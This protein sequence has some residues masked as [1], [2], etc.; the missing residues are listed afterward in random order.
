GKKIMNTI[1]KRTALIIIL[2]ILSQQNIHAKKIVT[3]PGLTTEETPTLLT[4][5]WLDIQKKTTDTV[6]QVFVETTEFNWREPYKTPEQNMASGSAFFIDEEGHLLSNF[7]VVNQAASIKIQ[8]PS[9]GKQRLD[10]SIVG[11]CPER[12]ISLLKLSQ[13]SREKI[14]TKL[15]KIPF[16][17]FG[18]SDKILRTHQVLALGYPL[19]QEKL[20]STQ[21]I[22]SGRENIEMESYIQTTAP[23]NPG[24]SG[25]PA[26]DENGN[27]IGLST[28]NIPE[29][30]NVGYIIPINNVKNIINDLHSTKLLRRPFFGCNLNYGTQDM[31]GYLKNPEPGGLY[32]SHVYKNTLFAKTGIKEGDMLYAINNHNIDMYGETNVQWSEDKVSFI[33]L[34][35]RFKLAEKITVDLYR[36]GTKHTFSFNFENMS[37]LPIRT[38]YP[39]YEPV[40]FEI[41]GGMVIMQLSLNHIN[42]F[43]EI[44]KTIFKYTRLENQLV[45]RLLISHVLPNSQTQQARIVTAGDIVTHVNGQV[46]TTLDELRNAVKR[47]IKFLSVKTE[48]KEFVV[49][50]IEKIV[51]QES[52]LSEQYFYKKSNLIRE[53]EDKIKASK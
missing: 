11:A 9:L 41:I 29:A 51:Y 7:H 21:G 14:I 5:K 33:D 35:N 49:L 38:I 53:L 3:K 24:N 30:Q 31:L 50:S 37:P 32:I 44:N 6:A 8:I 25:G 42:I 26:L 20:K 46:V 12:D 10:I 15:G 40:D 19:G 16:L 34:L 17:T 39:E 52:M 13:D 27:V 4:S 48:E 22:V 28:A 18:D 1:N 36:N 23:I 47:D 45:P 43:E 2:I